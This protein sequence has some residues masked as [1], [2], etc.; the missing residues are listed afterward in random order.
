MHEQEAAVDHDDVQGTGDVQG[1]DEVAERQQ[2]F[3]AVAAD[4]TGDQAEGAQRG[5]LQ[6]EAGHLDHD[7]AHLPGQL[8]CF[9]DLVAELDHGKTEQAGE[10]DHRQDRAAP[11]SQNGFTGAVDAGTDAGQRVE[12]VGGHD[13]HQH[14]DHAGHFARGVAVVHAEAE[15]A[16]AGLHDGADAKAHADRQGG[17]DDEPQEGAPAQGRHRLLPM[18]RGDRVDHREE[19]QR[20]R[21]HL[22]QRHVQVAQRS[23]PDLGRRSQ[24]PAGQGTEYEAAQHALPE[25]NPQP[26]RDQL[27]EPSRKNST[28]GHLSPTGPA[29]RG[30]HGKSACHRRALRGSA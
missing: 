7:L 19:H 20:H 30:A 16:A 12:H 4:Q 26:R 9:A 2:F 10:E 21:D 28:A 15:R 18:Q 8:A 6:H 1:E 23:E 11:G 13:I 22:D 5:D 27:H 14:L 3:K 29:A 24:Q 25:R 17:G